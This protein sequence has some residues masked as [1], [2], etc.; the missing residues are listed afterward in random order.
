MWKNI[1]ETVRRAIGSI[2]YE[3]WGSVGL[4]IDYDSKSKQIL[5][6]VYDK[7][8]RNSN[9]KEVINTKFDINLEQFDSE[10]MGEAKDA[11][12]TTIEKII[13]KYL[14]ENFI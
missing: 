10:F 4:Y 3:I 12:I 6:I 1:K 7:S 11:V 9:K 14:I 8:Y 13:E 2:V 5:F